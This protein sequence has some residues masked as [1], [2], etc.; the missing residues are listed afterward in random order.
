MQGHP[1]KRTLTV[2]MP[3]AET[4][5]R[6]SPR[7]GTSS[8]S[9][10]SSSAPSSFASG[11]AA[12]YRGISP[13]E[14][15]PTL[16]ILSNSFASLDANVDML[17]GGGAREG[18][19]EEC[20]SPVVTTRKWTKCFVER[21]DDK[22]IFHLFI[23]GSQRHLLTAYRM[24]DDFVL[25]QYVDI[26]SRIAEESQR[27]LNDS[28][29][30]KKRRNLGPLTSSSPSLSSHGANAVLRCRKS[31]KKFELFAHSCEL[32][33]GV[34]ARFTCGADS[35]DSGDRQLLG[36]IAH[37]LVYMKEAET[38]CRRMVVELPFVHPDKSRVVWCPRA[39]TPKQSVRRSSLASLGATE[40]VPVRV[41]RSSSLSAGSASGIREIV[42]ASSMG[43]ITGGSPVAAAA[44]GAAG[45]AAGI[46]AGSGSAGSSSSSSNRVVRSES[47]GSEASS[48]PVMPSTGSSLG[49][50]AAGG[51]GAAGAAAAGGGGAYVSPRKA[52]KWQDDEHRHRLLLVSKLPRWNN[53]VD[54]FCMSFHGH[55]IKRASSK[56]FVFASNQT[57]EG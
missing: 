1:R 55:R 31:A 41:R 56:N 8:S 6:V 38:S 33:D 36:E 5:R 52:G 51:A 40:A 28:G 9:S 12:A 50:N 4:Q 25:S 10:S 37:S 35:P 18:L 54:S 13:Q 42:R 14:M 16:S 57:A 32:C 7:T 53:D 23:E 24:G 39:G 2:A 17:E 45:M 19:S 20:L 26:A 29:G 21:T 47:N 11:A 30:R 48:T 22:K 43:Q 27:R 46:G 15:T 49:N 34:L 3:N 44:A